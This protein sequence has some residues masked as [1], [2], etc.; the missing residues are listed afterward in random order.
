MRID[1][2]REMDEKT[3]KYEWIVG[4]DGERKWGIVRQ[5]KPMHGHSKYRWNLHKICRLKIYRNML[6]YECMRV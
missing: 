6:S 3:Y 2:T 5:R 4:G 1:V